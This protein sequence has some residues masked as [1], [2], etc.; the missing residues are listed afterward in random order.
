[1]EPLVIYGRTTCEDTAVTRSRLDALGVPY[2]EMDIDL[3]PAARDRLIE[4]AGGGLSTPT[5]VFGD[6]TLIAV[7]PGLRQLDE[8]LTAAGYAVQAPAPVVYHGSRA[9]VPVPL[10]TL[11]RVTGGDFS[12]E[13]TRGRL[14]AAIFFAHGS[15]CLACSGYARQLAGQREALAE[16]AAIPIVVVADEPTAAPS[17]L[18]EIGGE[19]VVLA[20]AAGTWRSAIART[21]A[22]PSDRPALIVVDRFA[23]ARVGS[24]AAEAGGL[25][26]PAEATDWLRFLALECPECGAEIPWFEGDE[27]TG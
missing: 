8:L 18:R 19:V 16:A 7:E 13:L 5:L 20:D 24:F 26:T 17:W 11:P 23:A 4:L 22:E 1:M 10:R 9:S 27:L 21:L 25:I 6:R 12:L 3:D 14:Q 15:T 2:R